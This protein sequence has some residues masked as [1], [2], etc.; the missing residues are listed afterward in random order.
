MIDTLTHRNLAAEEINDEKGPAIML[1]QQEGI[2]DAHIVLVHPWQLRAVCEQFG[3]IASD[4]QAA[5]TIAT[6]QRRMIL[7]RDRIN[8]LHD[9][10]LNHSDHRRADLSYE[11]TYATATADI[12]DELC[13]EFEDSQ[14]PAS[15]ELAKPLEPAAQGTL[16]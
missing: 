1:T 14:M 5:T 11:L 10:L 4:P 7:L 15:V 6:L 13:A 16:L 12:A 9:Y 3:I 2:E 8:N